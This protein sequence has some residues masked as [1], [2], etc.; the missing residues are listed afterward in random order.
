M[1]DN[2]RILFFDV[3]R[4]FTAQGFDLSFQFRFIEQAVL[5]G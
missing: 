3:V 1:G 2:R 4:Q 5:V